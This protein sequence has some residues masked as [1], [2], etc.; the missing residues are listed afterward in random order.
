MLGIQFVKLNANWNADPNAP[1]ANLIDGGDYVELTFL[2]NSFAFDA[3]DGERATLHFTDCSRWL[4]GGT[5]DE[6]WY[7]GQCRYSGIAPTWGEFY[8]IV[9]DDPLALAALDPD[10]WEPARGAGRRHFL[11]YLRDETFE[12]FASDWHLIR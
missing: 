3:V 10:E 4:L 5:N 8:E 2:L 12:C 1:E 9:G 6:G 11:F 7:L